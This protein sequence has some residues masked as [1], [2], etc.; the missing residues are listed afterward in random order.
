MNLKQ[1]R[2]K[3]AQMGLNPKGTREDLESR[4]LE[5]H[6]RAPPPPPNFDT[7]EIEPLM[8]EIT[9]APEVRKSVFLRLNKRPAEEA[10]EDNTDGCDLIEHDVEKYT[11]RYHFLFN[12]ASCRV[13]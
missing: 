13:I 12:M 9:S 11:E 6:E 10:I 1:L 3:L 2:Q 5:T 7:S 8:E 4:L